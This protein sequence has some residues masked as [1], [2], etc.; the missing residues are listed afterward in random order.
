MLPPVMAGVDGSAESLAAADWAAREAMRRDRPLRLV[1]VWS[2]QPRQGA[3]TSA[4]AAQRYLARRALR[5]AEDRVRRV[6]PGVKLD[7]EQIE[8]PATAA[9]LRAAEQAELL[10][11]GSRGLSGFT[12]FLVGSVALGVVARAARPV[13]LVRAGEEASDEHL[14]ADDGSLS[15]HTGY[16]DVVLG[17]DL[18]DPCDDV[19]E[20]AF[21][22]A[23]LRGA[24]LHVV[25]AWQAQSPIGLGPGDIGLA[26]GPAQAD[27]WLGFLTAVLKVWRD[28]YPEVEVAET[29]TE[30]RA[31]SVL[32]RASTGASLVVVGRRMTER[33]TGPR[34]GPVTHA[35]IHHIGCPVA[36][37]PHE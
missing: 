10:V 20:F 1:H 23:R 11:L 19:I 28:K 26:E 6:C 34:T 12:G 24:R 31:Q 35:A 32:V 33:P 14:P 17:I 29:V 15:T 7:D 9:L 18:D 3:G 8:G 13:V 5:Q 21:E 27:E 36:V 37:V 22:A 4:T 2:W 25:H 16:R 30:G